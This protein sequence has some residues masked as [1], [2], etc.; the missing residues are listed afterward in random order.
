MTDPSGLCGAGADAFFFCFG[1]LGFALG[2]GLDASLYLAVAIQLGG[3]VLGRSGWVVSM[4]SCAN[5]GGYGQGKFV[6]ERVLA[7]SG[8]EFSSVRVG[9]VSGGKPRGAWATTDWFPILVKTS[10]ALGALPSDEQA[11]STLYS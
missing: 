5:G 1:L 3:R 9:Q 11:R 6:A 4:G 8:V 2:S 7:A 10:L